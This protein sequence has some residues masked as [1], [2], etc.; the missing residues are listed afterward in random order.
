MNR[1]N[2]G[3]VAPA[4]EALG[5]VVLLVLLAAVMWWFGGELANGIDNFFRLGPGYTYAKVTLPGIELAIVPLTAVTAS[6]LRF[7]V[8]RILA[9][10]ASRVGALLPLLMAASLFGLVAYLVWTWMSPQAAFGSLLEFGWLRWLGVVLL[11]GFTWVWLPLVPRVTATL[12]GM[13]AGPALFAIIG[14]S[15]F[16]SCMPEHVPGGIER[17]YAA[18]LLIASSFAMLVWAGGAL[19]LRAR[20]RT[21]TETHAPSHSLLFAT[22][23]GLIMLALALLGTL[24]YTAC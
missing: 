10:R 16:G 7:G 23:S 20:A 17:S 1:Q 2:G 11:A 13:I 5:W 12:A 21:G 3:T 9:L 8:A 6:R 4:V 14:Y 24:S 19:W 15:F 18:G 22:W